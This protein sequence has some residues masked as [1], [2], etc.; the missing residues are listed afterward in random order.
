M[1]ARLLGW[2]N[3]AALLAVLAVMF[4]VDL[5]AGLLL[6][7]LLLGIIAALDRFLPRGAIAARC[8]RIARRLARPGLLRGLPQGLTWRLPRNLL[9][10]QSQRAD[11]NPHRG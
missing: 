1:D 4:L 11:Q 5:G 6:L 9:G 10:G 8:S 7:L 3:H 2:L